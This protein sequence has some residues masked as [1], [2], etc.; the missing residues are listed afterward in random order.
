MSEHFGPELSQEAAA[1]LPG[2]PEDSFPE[3]T[4]PPYGEPLLQAVARTPVD[5]LESAVLAGHL[6]TP[7][8]LALAALFDGKS[9]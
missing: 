9:Y 1:A 4:R 5:W 7:D 6:P 2:P 3:W 8:G